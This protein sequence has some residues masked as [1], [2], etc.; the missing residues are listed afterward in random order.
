[1]TTRTCQRML[2]AFAVIL[3]WGS[4]SLGAEARAAKA[5]G[6]PSRSATLAGQGLRP[7]PQLGTGTSRIH[8]RVIAADSE[9]PIAGAQVSIQRL[10]N[11]QVAPRR[12][13]A[14]ANGAFDF[15]DIPAGRY[16]LSAGRAGYV[17]SQYRERRTPTPVAV[18]DRQ[19]AGPLS[20]PLPPG[21][22]IAGG[23]ADALGSPVARAMVRALRYRYDTDGNR[24]L[25]DAG[26]RDITDDLGRFRVHGLPAGDFIVVAS[27]M[28]VANGSVALTPTGML[29]GGVPTYHP[30][31]VN[32][33]EAQTVSLGAGAEASVQIAMI[34]G[35]FSRFGG[36]VVRTDGLPP[37][38]MKATLRAAGSDTAVRDPVTVLETGMFSLSNVAPGDYWLDVRG[39]RP[40]DTPEAASMPVTVGGEDLQW[41]NV[42]TAPGATVRG[43]V[44]FEGSPPPPAFRLN[45][46]PASTRSGFGV[47]RPGPEQ[48][49]IRADGSFE[50][51]GVVGRVV[52]ESTDPA[53][54]VKSVAVNGEELGVEPLD[55]KGRDTVSG[56]RVTLSDR[57]AT[58]S[59]RI[60]DERGRTL[61]DHSVVLLEADA[62]AGMT[63]QVRT[64]LSS[65]DGRFELRG[66]PPGLYVV[67]VVE[68]LEPGYHHSPEFQERLRER[69]RG[70]SLG[71]AEAVVVELTPTAGLP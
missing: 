42:A 30:G 29:G 2:G 39:G 25:V 41:L 23:V 50:M 43:S 61:A 17:A 57:L 44:A 65:A 71:E 32:I 18:A 45:L 46:L 1:M 35:R 69:G 36:T 64:I 51:T 24:S 16:V 31:T 62:T 54:T 3:M 47:I 52:F 60:V 22:V 55:V 68:E 56:V 4:P 5:A 27:E 63:P 13:T 28:N 15:R 21:A 67:G 59:G 12:T 11:P 20:L 38:G 37:L 53:W 66:L 34:A 58:V 9:G 14:D 19:T 8:G 70:F 33:A 49:A 6:G 7:P 10:G 40:G 48:G 26:V